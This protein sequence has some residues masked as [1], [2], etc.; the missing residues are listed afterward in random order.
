MSK[1]R[2]VRK[3]KAAAKR[4]SVAMHFENLTDAEVADRLRLAG[5]EFLR[6]KAWRELRA[7]AVE[8]YGAK[9]MKCAA[10]PRRGINVDHVKPRRLFP[11]LALELSN[12]Q[13]LCGRCNK[14]KGNL[15][16]D[17]R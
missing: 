2:E 17:Y 16:A 3:L 11:D 4:K 9:C 14:A 13:I 6:S 10:T 12:L 5:S 15:I 1:K 8:T 7:R